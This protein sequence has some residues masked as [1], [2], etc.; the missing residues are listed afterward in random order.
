MKS[1]KNLV[2]L[3]MMGS[4]KST[5]GRLLSKRLNLNFFD[6]DKIIEKENDKK[7]YE[8]FKSHGENFFRKLEE[9]LTLKTLDQNN[10]VISLGGGAFL[11]SAIRKKVLTKSVTFWL[12]WNTNILISRIKKNY[13]RPVILGL[14]NIQIKNLIKERSKTYVK[15]NYKIDCNSLNKNEIIDKI[16]KFY[17]NK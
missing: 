17:E 9:N 10:S 6:I 12:N 2:L 5:I 11:N 3:G 8:I 14:N 1:K 13:N 15:A 16:L 7:I 4:G